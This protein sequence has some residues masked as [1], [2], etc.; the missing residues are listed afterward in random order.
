MT[1]YGGYGRGRSR[2]TF[3]FQ[4][5]G[6]IV[7]GMILLTELNDSLPQGVIGF[8]TR[9]W[10]FE[11]EVAFGLMAELMAELAKAANG[12]TKTLGDFDAGEAIDKIGPQGLVLAMYGV[13]R[14]EKALSQIH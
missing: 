14:C 11:E 9:R 13:P 5:F 6:D 2:D 10:C 4:G 12:V 3:V 7:D 8:G 1:E